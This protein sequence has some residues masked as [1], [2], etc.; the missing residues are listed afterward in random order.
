MFLNS[1]PAANNR[2][3][4]A[5]GTAVAASTPG[6]SFQYVAFNHSYLSSTNSQHSVHVTYY[7]TAGQTFYWYCENQSPTLYYGPGHTTA[8]ITKIY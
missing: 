8:L 6:S 2:W 1:Q 5:Y 4:S 7:M 3:L